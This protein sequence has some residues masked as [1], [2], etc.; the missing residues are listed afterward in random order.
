MT[1]SGPSGPGCGGGAP[2][3]RPRPARLDRPIDAVLFDLD[4]TLTVPILDFPR[5]KEA[6]G[7]PQPVPILEWMKDLTP[8]EQSRV[9]AELIEFEIEAARKAVPADGAAETVAWLAGR[10]YQLGIVTRN[11]MPR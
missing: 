3:G 2:Q 11:C 6:V 1:A 10:G 4:G 8:A 7:C 9:E 5:I